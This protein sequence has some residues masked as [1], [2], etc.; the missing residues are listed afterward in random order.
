MC[1]QFSS[2]VLYWVEAIEIRLVIVY[3]MCGVTAVRVMTLEP[4]L[5]TPSERLYQSQ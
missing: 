2:K 1:E 4:N 5:R 3:C